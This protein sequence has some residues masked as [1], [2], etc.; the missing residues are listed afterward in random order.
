MYTLR[1]NNMSLYNYV[2]CEE[3]VYNKSERTC[4]ME[5]IVIEPSP[6]S[7]LDCR[8]FSSIL[9][10]SIIRDNRIDLS[11]GFFRKGLST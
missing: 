2:L 6:I 1:V 4:S 9:L 7:V 8:S 10:S 3:F 11:S 5:H